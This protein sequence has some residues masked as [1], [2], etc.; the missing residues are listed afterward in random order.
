[1]F[2]LEEHGYERNPVSF[3]YTFTISRPV[4]T[5]S[6]GRVEIHTPG[7][8]PHRPG[9]PVK[10]L[11]TIALLTVPVLGGASVASASVTIAAPTPPF[12]ASVNSGENTGDID[13]TDPVPASGD[14][15]L[16]GASDNGSGPVKCVTASRTPVSDGSPIT[17][18][19]PPVAPFTIGSLGGTQWKNPPHTDPSWR[20]GWY[21]FRWLTPLVQRAVDDGQ[22]A[23]VRTMVDQLLR[24]YREYPDPGRAIVGW[25]EGNSLRRLE[26]VNC[27]YA[28]TKDRR[29]VAAMQTEANVLFGDRYYGPPYRSVHNHGLMANLR[30]IEAGTLVGRNDWVTRAE[31]RVRSELGLAFSRNG[32]SNEQS[33][34]YQDVNAEM[35]AQAADTL[36]G[37][38]P[39][40]ESDATVRQMRATVARARGVAQ[41][42]TEPDGNYVQIG[43]STNTKGKAAPLRTERTFRD[44]VAGFVAGRWSWNNPETTYYTLRYGP[45]RYGHGHPDKGAV[46]WS[47]AGVRV[48]VGSGYFGYDTTDRFVRWQQTPDSANVAF[49]VGAKMNRTSMNLVSQAVRGRHHVW[50]VRSN[51]YPRTHTRSVNINDTT[52]SITVADHFAGRGNSDQMWHLDPAWQLVSAPRN[53]K[54]ATFRHPSGRTLEMRTTGVLAS[55][56][57][58][59]T[60]PVAGWNFTKPGSRTA[61]WEL[62][63]RWYSGSATTTFTVR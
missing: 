23:S 57:K 54:V 10:S 16:Q 43:D 63:V 37:L 51:V 49:P 4:P 33:A 17:V 29:L 25:D 31:A 5:G 45:A 2:R 20:L 7:P 58:G 12:V 15:V 22:T 28:L 32:T 6:G 41:W 46:T 59:G 3:V 8:A 18:S 27:I 9:V 36:S 38:S 30:L 40:G 52:R 24:F 19:L 14:G 1:M 50:R 42:L 47:T 53:T 13:A 48:L 61:A 34:T 26:S 21:S 44:D 39:E 11:A 35:W 55:A 62:R 56:K 60:N